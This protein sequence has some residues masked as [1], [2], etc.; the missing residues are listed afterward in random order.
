MFL[1][2]IA[3]TEEKARAPLPNPTAIPLVSPE[4]TAV[5]R[6]LVYQAFG[7]LFIHVVHVERSTHT[8]TLCFPISGVTLCIPSAACFS[9]TPP[10]ET[11]ILLCQYVL[12]MVCPPPYTSRG[13]YSPIEGHSGRHPC[14][15]KHIFGTVP[16]AHMQAFWQ[17]RVLQRRVKSIR[18]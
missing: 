9:A 12:T 10:Y 16:F 13:H 6:L 11:A 3:Y 18:T 2:F 4:V 14:F 7:L 8:T 17:N 1:L 15:I 5:T